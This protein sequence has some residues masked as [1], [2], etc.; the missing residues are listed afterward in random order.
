MIRNATVRGQGMAQ[1]NGMPEG[2]YYR[3]RGLPDWP[4]ASLSRQPRK[5]CPDLSHAGKVARQAR[6]TQ[7]RQS[8]LSI[9][10]AADEIGVT[11]RTAYGYEK[12]RLAALAGEEP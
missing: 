2:R 3:Y 1:Q 11:E 10:G 12:A 9:S 4:P 8:G 5:A 7:L 6:F